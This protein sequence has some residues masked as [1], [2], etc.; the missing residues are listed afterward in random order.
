VINATLDDAF[1]QGNYAHGYKNPY[2]VFGNTFAEPTWGYPQ[3]Y[4]PPD[5]TEEEKRSSGWHWW[6][7]LLFWGGMA[8]LIVATKGL[9]TKAIL[10]GA[11]KIK[12]G[13]ALTKGLTKGL[14]IGT[15]MAVGGAMNFGASVLHD[16]WSNNWEGNIDWGMVGV[17]T[18]FGVLGGITS[19]SP[20]GSTMLNAAAHGGVGMAQSL[21]VAL[22]KNSGSLG[23][24]DIGMALLMGAMNAGIKGVAGS[25]DISKVKKAL[26]E[27]IES[28]STSGMP[29][30]MQV[31]AAIMSQMTRL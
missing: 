14:K 5:L 1:Q 28:L 26:P 11:V 27:V 6:Q 17:R 25:F 3:V 15:H 12:K 29:E 19:A 16:R 7:H 13:A 2:D 21:T 8:L 9:A 30:D 20:F 31:L 23:W 10:K 22:M 18:G 4:M 24:G